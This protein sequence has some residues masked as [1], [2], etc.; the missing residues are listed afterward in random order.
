[1]R[2]EVLMAVNMKMAVFWEVVP[3]GLVAVPCGLTY[4]LSSSF[5]TPP[6]SHLTIP[7]CTCIQRTTLSWLRFFIIPFLAGE[8]QLHLLSTLLPFRRAVD[9]PPGTF[10]S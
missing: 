2:F 10:T 6:S 5:S 9:R 7:G 3:R 4:R 1:L 8:T